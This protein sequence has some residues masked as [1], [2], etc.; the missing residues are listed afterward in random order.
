MAWK[1]G[2]FTVTDRRE[3]LDI[4]TIHNF[5]QESYWAKGIPRLIVEKA[6]SNSLCFSL[7][8]NS[9]QVGFGRAISD[10]ATFA[11]LA[12][13]LWCQLIEGVASVNGW[14]LVFSP[15]PIFRGCVVGCWLRLM[16]MGYIN[17]MGLSLCESQ[18]GSWKSMT[19]TSINARY[20]N[21]FHGTASLT[22]RRP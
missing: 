20:N 17:K 2:E 21:R 7:Y 18:N 11:Y 1:Q 22:R 9:K 13:S 5:L 6:V 10:Q 14:C 4:E 3:D 15:I 16:L 19:Q 12:E 8:H